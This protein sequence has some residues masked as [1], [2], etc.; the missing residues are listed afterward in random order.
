MVSFLQPLGEFAGGRRFTGTLQ[1]RHQNYGGRLHVQADRTLFFGEISADDTRE[2][3]FDNPH[4]GLAGIQRP[5]DFGTERFFFD[6]ADEFFDD[7][8][9]H[10]GFKKRKT[11]FAR[12]FARIFFR[13][14]RLAAHGFQDF[15]KTGT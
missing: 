6:A 2:F 12:H 10:V 4:Q 1:P 8:E 15:G 5:H 14:A 9:G 7:G 13:E 11:N 3:L